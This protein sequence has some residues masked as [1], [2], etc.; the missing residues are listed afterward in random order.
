VVQNLVK[1]GKANED[2]IDLGLL[3]TVSLMGTL[4]DQD[5]TEDVKFLVEALQK[6]YKEY[7]CAPVRVRRSRS[8]GGWGPR[9]AARSRSTRRRCWAGAWTGRRHTPTTC[10]GAR[11]STASRSATLSL[12]G[13]CAWVP[14]VL[15]CALT[16]RRRVLI[17]TLKNPET[18]PKPLCVCLNDIGEFARGHARGKEFGHAAAILMQ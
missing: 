4:S 8:D 15:W 3:K 2:L 18:A 6:D 9:W 12:F 14:A 17:A 1:L 10:S 13:A 5:M 7:R 16:A 11:T